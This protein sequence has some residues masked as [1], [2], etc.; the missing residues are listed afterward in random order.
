[1]AHALGMPTLIELNTL[2][3]NVR[4]CAELKLNF[5]EIN[6]NLPNYQCGAL[7]AKELTAL[8][9]KYGIYFTLHLDENLNPFDFNPL[10]A[11]GYRETVRQSIALAKEADIPL[12]NLHMPAGVYFTL[13][14]ERVYLFERYAREYAESVARFGALC[15]EA[16]GDAPLL[17]SIEN[18]GGFSKAQR[19][20]IE[21]LLKRS[22][23]ALTYDTGHAHAAKN[24]DAPFYE[25]HVEK[26]RHLHIHDANGKKDHLPPGEG[27]VDIAHFL[28]TAKEH[29]LSCVVEV[30]T[31]DGLRQAVGFMRNA[32]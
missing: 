13:P 23:F 18:T 14:N 24:I 10:I 29:A 32:K 30:K 7:D 28:K 12:L 6:M 3:E 16:V 21:A 8:A 20:G 11:E 15:E 31:V 25:E 2:E 4:L 19:A 22:C 9:C 1:M 27:E 5:V 26:L 17:L